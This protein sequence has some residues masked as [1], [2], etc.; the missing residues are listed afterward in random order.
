MLALYGEYYCELLNPEIVLLSILFHDAIY[1]PMSSTNEEDSAQLF[2]KFVQESG[3]EKL[4][5]VKG[6]VIDYILCTKSHN[7]DDEEKDSDK[8]L[9][10][11]MD[12]AVLARDRERYQLY[13]QQIRQEYI[14]IN[15][16]TYCKVKDTS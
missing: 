11:D 7:V 1:N 16:E 2:Q 14:H 12:M 6:T 4:D 5:A 3:N 10:I 13:S 15:D 9:F 8:M